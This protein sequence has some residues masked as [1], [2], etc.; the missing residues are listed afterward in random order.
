LIR[1]HNRYRPVAIST[2]CFKAGKK[3][4]VSMAEMARQNYGHTEEIE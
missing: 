3:N 4:A 1:F 2:I